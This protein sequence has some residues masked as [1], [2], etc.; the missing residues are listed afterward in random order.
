MKETETLD[1]DKDL[2]QTFWAVCKKVREVCPDASYDSIIEIAYQAPAPRY[3]TSYEMARRFVS[4]IHRRQALTHG[5][6][7]SAAKS[8][9]HN[10]DNQYYLD[11]RPNKMVMY[12]DLYRELLRR[13]KGKIISYAPLR[14]II[15]EPAP[16]YYLSRNSFRWVIEKS[17]G[18]KRKK[19]K[20]VAQ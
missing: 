9:V 2:V 5:A 1:R 12:Y 16:S 11:F 20:E 10:R 17:L 19:K 14:E 13:S 7:L 4:Q 8:I 6:P 3:Y 18:N 15:M